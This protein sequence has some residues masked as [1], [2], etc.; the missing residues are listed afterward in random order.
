MKN[1]DF[2]LL[3]AVAGIAFGF[4]LATLPGSPEQ[5]CKEIGEAIRANQSFP[6]SVACYP[7]GVLDANITAQVNDTELKCVCRRSYQ[8]N[9][10]YFV[11]RVA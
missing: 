7:P 6:G 2:I 1:R 8:D 10:Q 3:M 9:V 4:V 5:E 11:I